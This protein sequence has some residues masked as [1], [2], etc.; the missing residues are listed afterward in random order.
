MNEL[1]NSTL[2]LTVNLAS[3]G[4]PQLNVRWL[5][6]HGHVVRPRMAPF[7]EFVKLSATI[8]RLIFYGGITGF[9]GRGI[10]LRNHDAG[11]FTQR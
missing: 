3:L 11:A 6:R 2:K 1:A 7:G 9:S 4:C 8:Q 10:S 5:E